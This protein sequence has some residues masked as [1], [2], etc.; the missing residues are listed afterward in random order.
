ME[1]RKKPSISVD[2]FKMVNAFN[3]V[4]H[5]KASFVASIHLYRVRVTRFM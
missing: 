3:G 5:A 2:Y 4:A 1:R